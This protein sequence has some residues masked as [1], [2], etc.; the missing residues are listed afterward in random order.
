LDRANGHIGGRGLVCAL[1]A[2]AWFVKLPETVT[3]PVRIMA[4]NP[5]VV[6][7]PVPDPGPSGATSLY[8]KLL[9]LRDRQYHSDAV[10]SGEFGRIRGCLAATPASAA[11]GAL[12]VSLPDGLKTSCGTVLAYDENMDGMV[13][14][15]IRNQRLLGG[16]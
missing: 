5:A 4:A 6:E 2:A 10:P 14:I 8:G 9:S 13:E 1:L 16:Y 3:L 12:R 11:P 15:V 7:T